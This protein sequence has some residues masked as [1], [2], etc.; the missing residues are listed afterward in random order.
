[1]PSKDRSKEPP[2]T[3]EPSRTADKAAAA[4]IEWPRLLARVVEGVVTAELH[5][6][7]IP[8]LRGCRRLCSLDPGKRVGNR[9]RLSAHRGDP[10]RGNVASMVGG[11]RV[12]RSVSHSTRF[13]RR[14]EASSA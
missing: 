13:D 12:G 6:Y 8:R 7:G 9:C 3:A 14:R 1:M 2:K 4:D 11:V 10:F 5:E